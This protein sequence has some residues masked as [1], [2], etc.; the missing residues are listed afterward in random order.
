MLEAWLEYH[1]ATLA[2]KCEGLD[3]DS[4]A[5]VR[6]RRRRCRCSVSCA[7]WPRSR[8]TGS[9]GGSP[10]K[11]PPRFFDDANRT[12]TSTV[13]TADVDEAFT[14]WQDECAR[15]RESAS[16]DSLDDFGHQTA[17][18]GHLGAVDARHMIEEY[19]RHNGHA[20]L[21]REAIDGA[22]GD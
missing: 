10:A 5:C 9:A 15:P 17:R 14:Y 22:T 12:T 2:R 16:F 21:L 19:A 1:R 4:S 7:T 18:R 13:D 20:D 11:S 6:C 3:D 8:R